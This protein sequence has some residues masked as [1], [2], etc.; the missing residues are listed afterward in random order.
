[1]SRGSMTLAQRRY[2][3]IEQWIYD[4][5]SAQTWDT[6][7]VVALAPYLLDNTKAPQWPPHL[8]VQAAHSGLIGTALDRKRFH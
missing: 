4:L 6:G 3:M 1:M 8:A 5:L 7:D 2:E